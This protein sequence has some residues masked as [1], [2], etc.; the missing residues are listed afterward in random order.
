MIAAKSRRRLIYSQ[1]STL[2]PVLAS[3]TVAEPGGGRQ[4]EEKEEAASEK[5]P[6]LQ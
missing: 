2:Q 1:L 4:V 6:D 3:K 5:L